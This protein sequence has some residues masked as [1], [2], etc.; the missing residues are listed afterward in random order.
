MIFNE[1][2]DDSDV[3]LE[4]PPTPP[5]WPGDGGEVGD[6]PPPYGDGG[7]VGGPPEPPPDPGDVDTGHQPG[8]PEP[9]S[10]PTS[11]PTPSPILPPNPAPN[12]PPSEAGGPPP[13]VPG[14]GFTGDSYE[15]LPL[16]AAP[17]LPSAR[18]SMSMSA[19]ANGGIEPLSRF[20]VGPGSRRNRGL[21]GGPG[22][23]VVGALPEMSEEDR[24]RMIHGALGR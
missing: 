5:A 1:Y 10:Q 13:P 23:P 2:E 18:G 21:F 3:D 16:G 7:D 8:D 15:S 14:G 24:L 6:P 9:P 4:G 20:P 22:A 11:P 12:P 19:G 17:S